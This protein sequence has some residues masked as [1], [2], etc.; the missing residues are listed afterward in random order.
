MNVYVAD[1]GERHWIAARTLDEAVQVYYCDVWDE[2]WTEDEDVEVRLLSAKEAQ[3]VMIN[4]ED[5]SSRK[6]SWDWAQQ[7]KEPAV[8]GS[9]VF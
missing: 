6:T 5:D 7:V 8:I 4:C 9:S 3:G 1:D 2:Y